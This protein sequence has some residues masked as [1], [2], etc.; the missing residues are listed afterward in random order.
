MEVRIYTSTGQLIRTLDLGYK[1]A[2]LYIGKEEAA[3]WDG[4]NETGEYV[5][6]GVYFYTIQ[7]GDFTATRKMVVER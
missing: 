7:A 5:S 4:R 3:H 1:L 6:S 2:G